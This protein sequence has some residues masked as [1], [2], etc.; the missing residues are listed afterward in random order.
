[1]SCPHFCPVEPQAASGPAE[2]M[3]PL[4]DLWAGVCCAAP[5]APRT[6]DAALWPLCN[7]GYA[8]GRCPRFPESGEPDA[9]RFSLRS[10]ETDLILIRYAIERNHHPYEDGLLAYSISQAGLTG[11][12]VN[13]TLQSQAE[14]Y[15]RSFLRRTE[16]H[17]S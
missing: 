14:A 13:E 16:T 12:D 15:A 8:R 7:L 11:A 3:L 10:V 1:M 9:V 4:G 5:K 2:A 6:V 17:A